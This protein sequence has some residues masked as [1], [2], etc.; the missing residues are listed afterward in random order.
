MREIHSLFAT[1]VYQAPLGLE[2]RVLKEIRRTALSLREIDEPGVE[3]CRQNYVGGYTS[4][5]SMSR[6]HEQFTPFERLKQKL[7]P[8]VRR[9]ARQLGMEFETG[10]LALSALWVNVMPRNCY[11][12]F[13]LHPLSV[14]SG[15]YYVTVGKGAS[16]LRIEDPRAAQFMA[17][18]PRQFQHDLK[19]R[20]GEIILFESW[21]RHEVPPHQMAQ[22][23]ISVSFNYDWLGR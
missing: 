5:G 23:R 19:P 8:V 18:P 16:P 2:P 15:T 22:D 10:E 14:I 13:H 4:Y 1:Q 11:H 21:L 9:F 7:D 6:L 17:A 20:D 12:A 3:W